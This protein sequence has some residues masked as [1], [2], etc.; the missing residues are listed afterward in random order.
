MESEPKTTNL[1]R[2]SSPE[3]QRQ[4][5][6]SLSAHSQTTSS[7]LNEQPS[8]KFD[9]NALLSEYDDDFNRD[10]A[11]EAGQE[12]LYFPSFYPLLYRFA[13]WMHICSSVILQHPRIPRVLEA[14]Y[15]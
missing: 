2:G 11:F 8:D 15:P 13:L 7:I 4:T 3:P 5:E 12:L 6:N 10:T 14:L 1:K 9:H